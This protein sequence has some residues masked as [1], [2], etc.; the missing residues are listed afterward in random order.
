LIRKIIQ[1]FGDKLQKVGGQP[2]ATAQ[3]FGCLSKGTVIYNAY[4]K[5]NNKLYK[6]NII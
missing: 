5:L 3:F 2:K 4:K 6:D 1:F